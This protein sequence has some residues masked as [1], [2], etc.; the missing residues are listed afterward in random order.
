MRG[1]EPVSHLTDVE[2]V[3]WALLLALMVGAIVVPV[4]KNAWRNL[5]TKVWVNQAWSRVWMRCVWPFRHRRFQRRA[6]ALE[7]AGLP[8]FI[9][10]AEHKDFGGHCENDATW[11]D[12]V[13]WADGFPTHCD[14]CVQSKRVGRENMR[15]VGPAPRP[16]LR[17]KGRDHE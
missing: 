1:P 8:V 16:T 14:A 17:A 7:R 13:T 4:V 12:T 2:A 5:W 15:R 3:F 11:A 6:E 9:R 10:C